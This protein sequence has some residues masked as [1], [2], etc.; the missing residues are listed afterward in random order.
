MKEDGGSRP[1]E[2]RTRLLGTATQIFYTEGINSVGIDRIISEANVTR[3]TMYRHFSGKEQ[4]VTAYLVEASAAMRERVNAL[5]AESNSAADAIRAIADDIAGSIGS[6]HF[7]GCAFLN[8]AA[9]FPTAGHPVRDAVIAHRSWFL[10]TMTD[11][12]EQ[13]SGSS[14]GDA[15]RHFVMLRDGAMTAGCLGDA[16]AVSD[17]F[18]R[19]VDGLIAR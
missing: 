3:A 12:F 2:A 10:A 5:V 18:L 6:A 14:A 17:T 19:A 7:R 15:G 8:A 1:S 9:E 11:L 16:D 4:L 13:A